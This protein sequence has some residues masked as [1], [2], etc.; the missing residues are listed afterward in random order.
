[1]D[2][3]HRLLD[4]LSR[5]GG[6]SQRQVAK[7]TGFSLGMVN[8]ILARLVK[9][10]AIKVVNLNGRTARYLLTPAGVAEKSRRAYEYIHR[11]MDTFRGLRV[12]IDQ[13]IT[14]LHAE[15]AREFLIYGEGEVADIA[16]LC[17]ARSTLPGLTYRRESGEPPAGDLATRAVLQC[18][19]QPLGT[20]YVGVSVL[21]RLVHGVGGEEIANLELRN[22][23]LEDA[24]R[25]DV[26]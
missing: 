24:S 14:E 23:N 26:K 5:D 12:R 21:E 20:G 3:E 22:A 25:R 7:E 11:T 17:L 1:M 18:S 19:M 8:L 16:E 15:G 13:L 6:L 9:T 2:K 10:G 4:V